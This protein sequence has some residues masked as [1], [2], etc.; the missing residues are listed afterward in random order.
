MLFAIAEK[1]SFMIPFKLSI[2]WAIVLPLTF[3]TISSNFAIRFPNPFT[4]EFLRLPNEVAIPNEFSFAK[5]ASIPVPVPNSI[6]W[7]L[8]S[9]NVTSPS[10]K[11]EYKSRWADLPV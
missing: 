1:A 8:K 4:T 2:F 10:F 9:S 6:N 3:L 5:S 7:L 11:A